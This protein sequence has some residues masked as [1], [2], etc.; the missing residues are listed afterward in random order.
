MDL[1]T[2]GRWTI[3]SLRVAALTA[4]L[5]GASVALAQSPSAPAS[6]QASAKRVFTKNTVFHLPIQMDER[7]RVAL[8]E[9]QLYVK[10]GSGDW[11]RQEAVAPGTSHFTY[12]V[13]HDG[14][15]SFG[16]VTVD[17]QGK[18][19]PS[20]IG[21]VQPVL[22][23]VVDTRPPMLETA[24]TFENN[25]PIL[26]VN[27]LDTNPDMKS[28]QAFVTTEHGDRGLTPVAGQ[29]TAFRLSTTDMN[30]PIRVVAADL[31]GNV[32]TK[33]VS[34]RDAMASLPTARNDQTII[35][36]SGQAPVQLPTAPAFQ[37]N[38]MQPPMTQPPMTQPPVMQSNVAPAT[39]P[40]SMPSVPPTIPPSMPVQSIPTQPAFV[41]QQGGINNVAYRP[42]SIDSDRPANRKIIN[43]TH[44]SVD[45]RIDTV[46]PSGVGRV[47]VYM[48]PDKG[49][50]W[51]KIAED[52]DKRS[53]VEID[54]PGEGLYGIRM[55]IS[56]GIGFGGKA[57]KSGDR[58]SF[59][60]EVDATS[61]FVQLQPTE[62]VPNTGAIDIRWTATDNNIAPEPVS[63]FYRT[64]PDGTWQAVARNVKNDGAY[65]WTFPRDIGAQFFLKLEV[66]D[67]AGN[68]TKVETPT[69]ILLD[70]TEPEATLVDVTGIQNPGVPGGQQPQQPTS[71]QPPLSQPPIVLPGQT[72]SPTPPVLVPGR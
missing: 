43:T 54:L 72:P 66:A 26:R 20:D 40:P 23:V 13:P 65:R 35:P 58:P 11:V 51:N 45:Y 53:P 4:G 59:F 69:P 10:S 31:C 50:S 18:V 48:S 32:V 7:M 6:T 39:L 62:M 42:N 15:Y 1:S 28:I 68:V 24:F 55:A 37:P 67:M 27:L 22:R 46:G 52:M 16:L 44:A 5:C 34:G 8:R 70:M 30:L 33:E 56:N 29:S 9:V 3:R 2:F 64:R 49:Q 17:K 38:M 60:I 61:P 19:N 63:I 14:E 36:V 71:S 21:A 47:D 25:E 12:R 41:P 57:P